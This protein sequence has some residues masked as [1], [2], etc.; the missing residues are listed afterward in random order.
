MDDL[1]QRA[2]GAAG[3]TVQPAAAAAYDVFLSYSRRE[4]EGFLRQERAAA[5]PALDGRSG[6]SDRR[7]TQRDRLGW[8]KWFGQHPAIRAPARPDPSCARADVPG[9]SN[10][11]AWDDRS[12]RELPQYSDLGRSARPW[13]GPQRSRKKAHALA[14]ARQG[15]LGRRD[16]YRRRI[17]GALSLSRARRVPRRGRRT[18]FRARKRQRPEHAAWRTCS[19]DWRA[20]LRR[21]RRALGQRQIFTRLCRAVAD[22]AATARSVLGHRL[23]AAR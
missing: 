7:L 10:T 12:S 9:H 4:A 5:R 16:R 20:Q 23:V 15:C 14:S 11:A 19:Q 6:K 8:P 18:V 1:A 2:D 3:A 21:H 22:A 17:R 13:R